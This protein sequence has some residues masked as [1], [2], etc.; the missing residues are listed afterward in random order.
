MM[1]E[2]AHSCVQC[3]GMSKVGEHLV[4]VVNRMVH[5]IRQQTAR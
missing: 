3:I 5:N 2:G 4:E 1:L